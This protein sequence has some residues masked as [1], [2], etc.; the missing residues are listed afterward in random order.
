MKRFPSI[1]GSHGILSFNDGIIRKSY[2]NMI[3]SRNIQEKNND[4]VL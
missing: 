2:N 4:K 3:Q 1:K